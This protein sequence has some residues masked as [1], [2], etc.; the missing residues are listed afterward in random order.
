MP[1]LENMELADDPLP[2]H[3]AADGKRMEVPL[4]KISM[5]DM[6]KAAAAMKAGKS[7]LDFAKPREDSHVPKLPLGQPPT[8]RKGL[9]DNSGGR[10]G[11]K[12]RSTR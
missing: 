12:M 5:A 2:T 9:A 10:G 11:K 4:P 6:L 8:K 7:S 3:G 1:P